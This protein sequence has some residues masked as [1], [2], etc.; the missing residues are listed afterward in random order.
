VA[1]THLLQ[2]YDMSLADPDPAPLRTPAF[3]GPRSPYK[4]H[5]RP[6]MSTAGEY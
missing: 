4:I 2:H 6:S 5:Y 1:V 3:K